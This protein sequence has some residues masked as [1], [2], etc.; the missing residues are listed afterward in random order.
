M[1]EWL[2]PNTSIPVHGEFKHMTEHARYAQQCG[3]KIK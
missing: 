2:A 1:Y 3:I